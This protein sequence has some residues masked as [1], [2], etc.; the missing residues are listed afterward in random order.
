MRTVLRRAVRVAESTTRKIV[1]DA[2][3]RVF[4]RLGP[5]RAI[6]WPVA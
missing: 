1:L 2:A 4:E 5:K 3:G 6:A